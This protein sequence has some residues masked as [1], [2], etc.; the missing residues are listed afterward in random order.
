MEENKNNTQKQPEQKKKKKS[1]VLLTIALIVAIAVF[2]YAAFNL[3]HIY[4]EYKKG[5]DEY[6]QIE[7]MAVTERDADSGEVAGPNA[8]LKPPI[9]VDF[10]KLKSV[11]EDVVGWI[12]VDALPDISYP[13]VKGKDNQTYLHQTYEKNYNFAGTIFVDY[14]NSGDFSDCNTL[15]YGHNMKNGSMFGHLKKF[16]EDDRLYKQ[17]KYFW[18]L[19]PER[20]YRYEIISAYTT[21]VNSDTYTLFKG[22]GEEFEKYLETIKGYSEIQTDDTDLTIKDKIVTLSTCTGNESTRFVVQG[23][24]VDAEDADGAAAN[25]GSTADE[26][27]TDEISL[28]IAG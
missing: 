26:E 14:E 12:Y 18:I 5:T 11:N 19:T 20:N 16:R 1:D 27:N 2:C 6:N 7:E 8:Q 17:D 21:G 13:I 4:T 10:D 3:Y 28:D 24:R 25:T 15:V 23:K 9:E 22:P